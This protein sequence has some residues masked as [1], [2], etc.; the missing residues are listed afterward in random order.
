MKIVITNHEFRAHFPP[1]IKFLH[2]FLKDRGHS[3]Y[4]IELFGKSI[5]Y[6]FSNDG[7]S[8]EDYW[9]ILF[10]NAE[11]GTVESSKI[12]KELTKSLSLI[13]PD[14]VISGIATFPVGIT[15]LRWAKKNNKSIVEFGDAK[16]D[17]FKHNPLI[18][19]IKRMMFR[20]VDAFLCPAPSFDE[21]M[22]FWGFKKNEIFYGL[23]VANNQEW[24]D[25]CNDDDFYQ[26]FRDLP[27]T[28]Y[29]TCSRQV[30][31]KNLP[32]LVKCYL[33]YQKQG[34]QIPLVMVGEGIKHH[35]L[36]LLAQNNL[37][38]VFL[39]FQ[40]HEKMKILFSH[41]KALFVPSFKEETWGIT[42]NEAMAS[43]RI[44]AVSTEAG[45][46][47]TIIKDGINGFSYD[48][49]DE[50]AIVQ[51]MHKIE[52][53]TPKELETMQKNA[54]E[55]IKDWGV[56]RFAS[57]ALAACEYAIAHKK[58]VTNPLDALLIRIWKGRMTIKNE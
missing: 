56:E 37:K 52:A 49:Y 58:K 34:G 53:L 55:T 44:A 1:R 18:H 21:S 9:K 20:N 31:M 2:Q 10:P 16:K 6:Q 46:C 3:L 22:M 45:C 24:E 36:V 19:M 54:K 33:E 14:V 35:E 39:P 48:P 38:I 47:S 26:C 41:M 28:F 57:G 42:V 7:T 32:R 13:N 11:N 5:C 27:T 23:D 8:N 25:N 17:T 50:E 15:A 29:L 51:T 12:D 4:V 40:S 30:T 43:Q